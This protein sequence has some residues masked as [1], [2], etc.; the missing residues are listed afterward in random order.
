MVLPSWRDFLLK[1][2]SYICKVRTSR[3]TFTGL[4]F[5]L[6]LLMAR[7]ASAQFFGPC[8]DSTH[9][10]QPTYSCPVYYD[11]YCACDGK[12]YRN[13]CVA[14]YQ[15]GLNNFTQGGCGELDVFFAPNPIETGAINLNFYVKQQGVIN[16]NFY[17]PLGFLKYSN[18]IYAPEGVTRDYYFDVSSL[19]TGIYLLQ[20]RK[21][22]EQKV[23]KV[24]I[25]NF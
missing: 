4:L 23:S 11:P 25:F 16:V 22:G 18:V 9:V 5:L 20:F 3:K 6:L 14:Y 10:A 19:K 12:T 13:D 17:D 2:A 21:G 8:K 1:I 7:G 24:F 15:H